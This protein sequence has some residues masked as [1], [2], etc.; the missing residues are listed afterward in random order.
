MSDP[1]PEPGQ[2][3]GELI[4]GPAGQI[5]A[6]WSAPRAELATGDYAL[7]CHPHPLLGGAMS[8][9]VTYTLAS[10]AQKAG[11][12]ALRFNF[13]GVGKS[14]GAHDHAR[15]ET[16]DVVFL[17]GWLRE[18]FPQGRLLLAGFSF[19][20]WVSVNAAA[21][22]SPTAQISIAPP[23]AKY[24]EHLP[25]PTRPRCPWLVVH[26]TDDEVVNYEDTRAVLEKFSP[27]PQLITLH[28]VGHFFHGKLTQLAEQLQPFIAEHF[29]GPQ[30]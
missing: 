6:L 5:E 3:R 1:F 8:N 9:K 14:Q 20:A 16:D 30:A 2:T 27:P 28:E 24:F 11:L 25:V 23:F 29:T 12:H 22:L 21:R 13:R 17:A 19:G 10:C 26:G 15:G 4:A 18:R 7:I